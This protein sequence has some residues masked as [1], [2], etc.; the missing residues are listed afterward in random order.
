[1]ADLIVNSYKGRVL[2]DDGQISTAID[3]ESDTIKLMLLD[4]SHSTDI[5]AHVFIDD[6]SA[7]EVSASGTY[8]SG[9]GTLTV[10]CSTD[11]TNDLGKFDAVD[12]AFTS[13]TITAR[14]AIFWVMYT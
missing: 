10:T 11:D 2:G 13:A 3:L 4:S 7:N 6:V 9:G 1:M 12:I 14:Y 8:S 5:D